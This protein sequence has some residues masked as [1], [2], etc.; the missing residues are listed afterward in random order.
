MSVSDLPMPGDVFGT[1][2]ATVIA[3]CWGNDD[4]DYGPATAFLLLLSRS[5]PHYLIYELVDGRGAWRVNVS[6]DRENIIPAAEL[7][8]EMIGGY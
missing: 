3:S 6:W 8:S 7:Y 2:G 1:E 5:A 4:S